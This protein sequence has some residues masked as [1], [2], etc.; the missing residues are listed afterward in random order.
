M[1]HIFIQR[2]FILIVTGLTILTTA[3]SCSGLNLG[4]GNPLSAPIILGILKH[5][6][7]IKSDGFGQINSVNTISGSK[8]V[9]GLSSLS[10]SKITQITKDTL[11]LLTKSKG[12]F[13]TTNGGRDWERKYIYSINSDEKDEKKKTQ[14]ISDKINKNDSFTPSDFSIDKQNAQNIYI[15]GKTSDKVGKIYNSTD[16]G[17]TFKLAYSEV[18]SDIGVNFITTDP[19]NPLRTYATLDGGSLI[20]T[21]DGGSTWSKIQ[22]FKESPIQMGFNPDKNTL[23]LVFRT[24]GVA[25]SG[26]DGQNWAFQSI[27]KEQLPEKTGEKGNSG[28]GIFSSNTNNQNQFSTFEKII[29]IQNNDGNVN[30]EL[31]IADSQLWFSGDIKTPFRKLVLP[32]QADQ[33]NILDVTYDKN[34]G[35]DR[36]LVSVGNKLL[37][38]K[39]RGDS[40][41]SQDKIGLTSKIGNIGQILIDN[42]N[43]ET[44][45][46][47]LLDPKLKKVSGRFE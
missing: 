22:N 47:M 33:Q 1:K 5:D 31:L 8:D 35:L 43:S 4:F 13:K 17:D 45:Y 30:G 12:L 44:I 29:P 46:L 24:L 20:R 3:Q 26:D 41:N 40:W 21:L 2:F 7:S 39:N 34:K 25:F 16:G 37:E 15:S 18:Q 6:P 27:T 36:I 9:Q 10:G 19:S 42:D 28:T 14:D 32:L 38:T 11:M 23:Y